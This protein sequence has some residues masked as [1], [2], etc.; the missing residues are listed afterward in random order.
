MKKAPTTQVDAFICYSISFC[1]VCFSME[2]IR[3]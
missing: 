1:C 3:N 2:F